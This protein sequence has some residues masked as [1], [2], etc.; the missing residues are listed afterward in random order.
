MKA[1]TIGG[2]TIDVIATVADREI[3][4]ITMHNATS[5]F[6]LLEEGRK[7]EAEQ[8]DSFVGGGA[9]NAAVSM[10]RQGLQVSCLVKLGQDLEAE[11][12]I[13]CLSEEG[14][15]T[16][17]AIRN[18]ALPTAKSIMISSHVNNPTI[19][20]SRGANTL[21]TPEE[22]TPEIFDGQDLVYV[23]GLS[24]NSAACFPR[25]VELAKTAGA[26]VA[27]NPGIRQLTYR[28]QEILRTLQWVDVVTLNTV[29]AAQLCVALPLESRDRLPS[30]GVDGAKPGG[31]ELLEDGLPL[32]ERRVA[33]QKFAE[34]MHAHGP[35]TVV[36]TNGS[37]GAYICHDGNIHF[38]PS[39]PVTVRGTA[40]AGDAFASTF[41]AQQALGQDAET[42]AKLAAINAASVVG[43]IDT[44]S[45]LLRADALAEKL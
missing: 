6:L 29:E 9:T 19:F 8:I 24:G 13:S 11:K 2:A 34:L 30:Q 39:L 40:G 14:I 42:A 7:V 16:S 3:E 38:C 33:L 36:V 43:R 41:A 20:V 32:G 18:A 17:G 22:I 10:A 28:G 26:R 35:S 1:L 27:A 21:L 31:P 12:V 23:T 15:D 37:E 5:S 45:G 25:I 4:R 44:Q